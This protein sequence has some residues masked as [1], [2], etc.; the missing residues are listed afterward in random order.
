[1]Y[2]LIFIFIRLSELTESKN[3][4]RSLLLDNFEVPSKRR[5]IHLSLVITSGYDTREVGIMF[6]S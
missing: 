5:S 4:F 2:K 3:H 1:M 6:L